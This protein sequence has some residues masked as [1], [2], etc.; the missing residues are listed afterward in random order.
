M[1]CICNDADGKKRCLFV[2]VDGKRKTIRLGKC[3]K[4]VAEKIKT[5]VESLLSGKILGTGVDRDDAEWLATKGQHVRPLLEAVG[6]VVPLEPEPTTP[7]QTL[8]QFLRDYI[9][10]RRPTVKPGTIEVWEQVVANLNEHMPKGIHLDEVTGGHARAFYET[11][12]GTMASSTVDKRIRFCRQF[13]NDAVEWEILAKNP[14][15]KIKT[16]TP[17][18]KSNVEVTRETVERVLKSCDPA[19]TLIVALSRYGGLRC[20]SEVL[21]LRWCD[22]DLENGMMFIPEPKVEHHEGRG[23][24]TC[25]IF[26]ELKPY[27]DDAWELRRSEYVVDSPIYRERANTATGWRNAN[28]RT[29]F[30]RI[31]AKAGVKPWKRLF[32]SMRASRQTELEREHPLH[33][34]CAWLGNTE[35]I[36]KKN[37]LL[38]TDADIQRAQSVAQN[39]AQFDSK[40]AQ[41]AAQ[42]GAR[43]EHASNEKSPENQGEI[44]NSPRKTGFNQRRGQDSNTLE[45]ESRNT[46]SVND[47]QQSAVFVTEEVAQN[48]AQLELK[49][50]EIELLRCWQL[51]NET[52]RREL[53]ASVQ[54][55][56][57]CQDT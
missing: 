26:G 23:V 52:A 25:P 7:K 22:V 15:A 12:K 19:W 33:V 28:L 39:P 53:L 9:D 8:E 16:T 34:T 17:A 14:F 29:Q 24:R 31:L 37:Y 40:V 1:A 30:L 6:L 50:D 49:A 5:R 27:L 10:R 48:Q 43:T 36:A 3:S 20:P 44:V 51:L 18:T 35:R 13:F 41:N 57:A 21:S 38:V 32:H 47:L 55:L 4:S 46:R 2:D 11:I 56:S 45:S 54:R 42:Q